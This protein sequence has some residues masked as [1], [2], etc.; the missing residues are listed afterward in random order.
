MWG[1]LERYCAGATTFN[2]DLSANL[3]FG[4]GPAEPA[5]CSFACGAVGKEIGLALSRTAK[6]PD[7]VLERAMT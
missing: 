7:S 3:Y 4:G 5:I 1:L 6:V 2:I